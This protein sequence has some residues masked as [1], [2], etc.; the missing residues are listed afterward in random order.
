MV[1]TS[2]VLKIPRLLPD[3]IQPPLTDILSTNCFRTGKFLK[4]DFFIGNISSS[5]QWYF[6]LISISP[7]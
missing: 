4:N 3:K 5:L 2:S 6:V 7:E 1:A